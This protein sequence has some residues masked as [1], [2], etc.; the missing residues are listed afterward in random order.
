MLT[1]KKKKKN[2]KWNLIIQNFKL[3]NIIIGY[4]IIFVKYKQ[5]KYF[6][7]RFLFNIKFRFIFKRS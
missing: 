2:N 5:V 7:N 4:I 3:L 6:I 1:Q